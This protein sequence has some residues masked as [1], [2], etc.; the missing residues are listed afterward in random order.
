MD[1]G[2]IDDHWLFTSC[3]SIVIFNTIRCNQLFVF[4]N[5]CLQFA[6][7]L[8]FVWKEEVEEERAN[9]AHAIK[10]PLTSPFWK[11]LRGQPMTYDINCVPIAALAACMWV[12]IS[13][14]VVQRFGRSQAS[15][16]ESISK[17]KKGFER[18]ESMESEMPRRGFGP[19]MSHDQTML[20]C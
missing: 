7:V 5:F 1:D 10:K 19:H 6:I 15:L 12:S 11:L 2:M 9:L 20:D 13:I 18:S 3:S 16:A 4:C 17:L 8:L 14:C